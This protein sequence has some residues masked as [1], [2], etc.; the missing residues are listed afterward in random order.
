[1]YKLYIYIYIYYIYIAYIMN[2][3]YMRTLYSFY[4]VTYHWNLDPERFLKAMFD[5]LDYL[6]LQY[7]M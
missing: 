7:R 4:I 3:I 2:A 6:Y 5:T 1:M